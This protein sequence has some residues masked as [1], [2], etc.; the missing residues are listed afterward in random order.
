MIKVIKW[1]N[2]GTIHTCTKCGC[3][4]QYQE[5]DTKLSFLGGDYENYKGKY[6]LMGR[7]E[8]YVECPTCKTSCVVGYTKGRMTS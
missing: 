3:V 7:F 2:I 1:G 5:G 6:T 4:F 8:Q